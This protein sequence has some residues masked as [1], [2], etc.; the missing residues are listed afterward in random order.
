MFDRRMTA[1]VWGV[2]CLLILSPVMAA[3]VYK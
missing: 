2:S 3:E 1:M